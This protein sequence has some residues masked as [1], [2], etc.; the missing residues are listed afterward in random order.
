VTYLNR[1]EKWWFHKTRAMNLFAF[2]FWWLILLFFIL[3]IILFYLFCWQKNYQ[4]CEQAQYALNATKNAIKSSSN[5]GNCNPPQ[6][7]I[8]CNTQATET[9]EQG[10]H[11]NTHSLGDKPGKVIISYDMYEQKDKMDVYYADQLVASTNQMV[12]DLG[13][14]EFYYPATSGKPKYCKIVMTAPES[15]TSWTYFLN[16]PQ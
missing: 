2:R 13:R 16:C 9:G 3:C 12:S 15:G 6:D 4:S 14:L 7:V 5:C 8:P 10:Y 11:E 1:K